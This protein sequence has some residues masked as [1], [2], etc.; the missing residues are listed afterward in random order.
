MYRLS[1]TC[2]RFIISSCTLCNR[3][4]PKPWFLPVTSCVAAVKVSQEEGKEAFT[5]FVTYLIFDFSRD[6]AFFAAISD[7]ISWSAC[8]GA[9]CGLFH[10]GKATYHLS[11]M[12]EFLFRLHLT[13]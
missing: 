11:D 13:P 8:D 1:L 4:F 5:G 12:G 10:A 7:L 2:D 6:R 3:H 9:P